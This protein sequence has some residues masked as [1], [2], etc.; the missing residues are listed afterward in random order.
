MDHPEAMSDPSSGPVDRSSFW[1][2][3]HLFLRGLGLIYFVAFL[4]LGHQG[5]P[6]MGSE[7]LLPADL[8]LQQVQEQTGSLWE[9]M[10]EV[11][12]LFHFGIS[13]SLITALAWLGAFLSLAVLLG[14]ANVP[15]LVTLWVLYFSFVSIG[16]RWFHFGWESQLLETGLL[17]VFLVPLLDVRSLP[18]RSPPPRII[19]WAGW[20]LL[21]RIMLGSG[22]IKLRGDPCWQE[23]TCL[24]FHF[25]TQPVPG[26]M[27][28][29]FHTLPQG[30]L[31]FGVLFNH[32]TELIAP[33]FLIGP[34]TLRHVAALVMLGF[35]AVLI[36][37][38]NLAFLNWLTI[39]PCLLCLDDQ[40]LARIYPKRLVA[41]ARQLASRP[42]QSLPRAGQVAVLAYAACVVWLSIPVVANL[43]S[44][45]QSMNRSF[46]AL[47][48]VNTYGAFG[49][50]GDTRWEVVLEGTQDPY[51]SDSAEWREYD[52][53]CKPGPLERRP[54]LIT[55]YHY[56]LDWLAWFAG[57]EAA[58]GPGI[59]R[60][61]WLPH[62]IWKL[63]HNDRGA[64]S[65]LAGN[66]FPSGPPRYI[67][68]Q[69]YKY[70]FADDGS[71]TGAWWTRE[72]VRTQLPPLS[73]TEK[74]LQSYLRGQGWLE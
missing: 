10:Q 19:V 36:A 42:A 72:L 54:C 44:S 35:Q 9:A 16:Q 30:V 58:R 31:H 5:L 64:L 20:W 29:W 53:K 61:T 34:R 48:I 60:E 11:P 49:S 65:L 45:D 23:L 12:T 13:D 71:E 37:S 62:L 69:L 21:F 66:P 25:E 68:V 50:V 17:A 55:P 73:K 39:L 52:F 24:D 63:L 22:L 8:W 18:P 57:L 26:P 6:L 28:R 2:T 74:Q 27:S 15:I 67:R 56:R 51:P 32:A 38:G 41:R 14:L 40:L 7:G 4:S 43:V 3:R 59:R 46:Q 47:R 1:L 70:R 33:F